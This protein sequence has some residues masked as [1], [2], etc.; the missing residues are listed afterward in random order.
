M[1]AVGAVRNV[2]FVAA[3]TS[4]CGLVAAKPSWVPER[5]VV[6]SDFYDGVLGRSPNVIAVERPFRALPPSREIV[7]QTTFSWPE[8]QA[9]AA[10]ADQVDVLDYDVVVLHPPV[11]PLP[12][13]VD[14]Q[15]GGPDPRVTDSVRAGLVDGRSAWVLRDGT[16]VLVAMGYVDRARVL[17]AR[18]RPEKLAIPGDVA[19]LV[20]IEDPRES[21]RRPCK[22]ENGDVWCSGP[23]GSSRR[24]PRLASVLVATKVDGTH[25]THARYTEPDAA[26]AAQLRVPEGAQRIE[27]GVDVY[28][29]E[30]AGG[31][32]R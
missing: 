9:L 20:W 3:L 8:M 19:Q 16:W 4:A 12:A 24:P 31:T 25:V 1:T 15:L 21:D 23:I 14:A 10:T 27:D 7:R 6:A 18:M 28:M 13:L 2:G 22:I 30:P 17:L 26:E 11:G 29:R 5:P 32:R